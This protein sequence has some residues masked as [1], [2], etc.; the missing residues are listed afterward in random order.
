MTPMHCSVISR[1][2]VVSC[3]KMRPFPPA[4][5]ML[6][7]A[8]VNEDKGEIE[9]FELQST[10]DLLMSVPFRDSCVQLQSIH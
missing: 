5:K 7:K 8:T 2:L 3:A 10:I 9:L 1:I 4:F 6:D